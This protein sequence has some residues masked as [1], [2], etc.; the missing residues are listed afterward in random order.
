MFFDASIQAF[1]IQVVPVEDE[2]HLILQ[3]ILGVVIPGPQGQKGILPAGAIKVPIGKEMAIKKAKEILEVA[4]ALPDPEPEV[5]ESD[6]LVAQNM[7]QAKQVAEM[8][9]QVREGEIPVAPPGQ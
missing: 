4:E 1:D 3:F 2:S 5:P 8:D 7:E 6:I 9:R